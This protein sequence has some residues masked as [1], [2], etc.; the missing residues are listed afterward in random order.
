MH[1]DFAMFPGGKFSHLFLSQPK[2]TSASKSHP[3]DSR[4][5]TRSERV[6]T[7]VHPR[8]FAQS[9]ARA[10]RREP[11]VGSED[12]LESRTMICRPF[13]DMAKSTNWGYDSIVAELKK[14]RRLRRNPDELL[15][16]RP[17][18]LPLREFASTG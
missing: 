11:N 3:S 12:G 1:L 15:L 13:I 7:V 5:D 4:T 9:A 10:P 2:D 16:Y 6:I 17:L 8:T 18:D 14:L